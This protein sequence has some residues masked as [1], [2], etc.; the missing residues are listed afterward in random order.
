MIT[1]DSLSKLRSSL[2]Q[3]NLEFLTYISNRQKIVDRIQNEKISLER[4][5]IWDPVQELKVFKKIISIDQDLDINYLYMFSMLIETQACSL[6]EYPRWTHAEHLDL[7]SG[8]ICDFINPILLYLIDSKEFNRLC[9][10]QTFKEQL[11]QVITK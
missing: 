9:L 11:N 8:S 2:S 3:F 7:K 1:E 4:V 5:Q 6:Y 10:K